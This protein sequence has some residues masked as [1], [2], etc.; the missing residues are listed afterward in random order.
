MQ[1]IIAHPG[2]RSR[3]SRWPPTHFTGERPPEP[4]P[5]RGSSRR[6]R[7]CC[8]REP[9]SHPLCRRVLGRLPCGGHR[10]RDTRPSAR[11]L[12]R[13]P[14]GGEALRAPSAVGRDPHAHRRRV[15]L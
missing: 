9:S 12:H 15:T 10:S 1:W 14:R 5:A 7:R 8:P 4:A 11:R 13:E 6:T 3:H 2:P